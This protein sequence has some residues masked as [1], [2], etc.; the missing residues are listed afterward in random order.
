LAAIQPASFGDLLRRHRLAAGLTQEQLAE[1]AQLSARA[2]SDLERGTRSRPWR[3]TIRLLATA[4]ALPPAE[5]AEL[6]AA[7]RRSGTVLGEPPAPAAPS[8]GPNALSNL[9]LPITSFVG[10]EREL[11]EITRLLAGARLLTLTGTGGCG[12]TRLALQVGSTR[13]NTFPDGVWLVDLAP[14]T[15][16]DLVPNVVATAVGAPQTPGKPAQAPLLAFLRNRHL[17]LIL[18]NCEHLVDACAHLAEA[19]L[20]SC[21]DVRILAT[22]REPLGIAGEVRWRVPSLTLPPSDDEIDGE[23]LAQSEAVRLFVERAGGV[24]VGFALTPE[25]T[26]FVFQTCRRLDGIPL[27]LELAATR[28]SALSVEQIAA[29]LDRSFRLLAGGSRTALPRQQTIYNTI[30]WSYNLL[31]DDEQRLFRRLAVFSHPFTLSAVLQVCAPDDADEF[32]VLELLQSLTDKNMIISQPISGEPSFRLLVLLREFGIEQLAA[33]GQVEIWDKAATYFKALGTAAAQRHD[34]SAAGLAFSQALDALTHYPAQDRE[35][36]RQRIDAR[37]KLVEVVVN[38]DEPRKNL[39]RLAEAETLCQTLDPDHD[40]DDRRY[41]AWVYHWRGRV[42]YFTGDSAA[43]AQAYRRTLELA[44]QLGDARLLAYPSAMVGRIYQ[45]E[46]QYLKAAAM[47]RQ[48]VDGLNPDEDWAEWGTASGILALA[49]AMQGNYHPAIATLNGLLDHCRA[50]SYRS[51]LA[52]GSG[53]LA[54]LY[55]AGGEYGRALEA[56]TFTTTVSAETGD[57]VYELIGWGAGAWAQLRLGNRARAHAALDRLRSLGE[58][59]A[60][61]GGRLPLGDRWL[62]VETELALVDGDLSRALALAAAICATIGPDRCLL[63]GGWAH[64]L[65][66]EALLQQDPTGWAEAQEHLRESVRVLESGGN[67][68]EAARTRAVWARLARPHDAVAA[69]ALLAEAGQVF[70]EAGLPSPEVR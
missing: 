21:A 18:D 53:L 31:S 61:P 70:A 37:L 59:L 32:A 43:A 60:G 63:A 7:A 49:E 36:I 51:L 14:L 62:A 29:R 27:A 46:G 15:D 34:L 56:G 9:P 20:Q 33:R 11:D 24:H 41:L 65:W 45:A 5:R 52:G 22:S 42:H 4:L 16:P 26:R 58:R 10:R 1:K 40:P 2:V 69:S 6:E 67:L 57:R 68:L 44:D 50:R 17:L 12:K 19:I 28:V 38:A 48:A 3:D 25:N 54:L 55:L 23:A 30:A 47:L 35:T 66:A 39:E 8:P 13:L 64:R